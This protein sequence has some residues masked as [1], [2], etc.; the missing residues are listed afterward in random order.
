MLKRYQRILITIFYIILIFFLIASLIMPDKKMSEQE[1]RTL[2]QFPQLTT[3][4]I[5]NGHF[6]SQLDDYLSDQFLLRDQ[7][8]KLKVRV[9]KMEGKRESAGVYLGHKGYLLAK[10]E[11]PNTKALNNSIKAINTFS[12]SHDNISMMIIPSSAT[13]NPALLPFGAPMR[14]GIKDINNFT[15]QLQKVQVIDSAK[16]LMKYKHDY[17]YYKE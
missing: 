14:D 15:K 10:N 12:S 4:S 3:T 9:D 16:G 2:T 5:I 8:M 11:T 1:N 17:L 13:I 6:F 7:F